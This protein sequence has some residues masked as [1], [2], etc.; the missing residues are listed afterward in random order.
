MKKLLKEFKE[1]AL[2]GNLVEVAVGLVLAIA[3]GALVTSL[4]ENIIM[5]IVAAI[6][7]Q[8]DFSE[9]WRLK[10]RG[11]GPD[12][13]WINFGTFVTAFVTF[14]SVAFA[15]YFFVVKPWQAYKARVASGEEEAPVEP[16]EEIVLLREIRDGLARR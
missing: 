1:F 10:L 13:T 16:A 8:P 7:G 15:V 5:P 3:L 9:L 2:G 14:L 12:A 4:V 11:D 6:F